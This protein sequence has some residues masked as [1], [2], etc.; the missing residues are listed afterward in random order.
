MAKDGTINGRYL[1]QWRTHETLGAKGE[2]LLHLLREP[3]VA[4]AICIC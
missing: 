4:L 3:P 1:A 2:H